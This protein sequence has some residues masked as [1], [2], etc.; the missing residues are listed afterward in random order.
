ML[1]SRGLK[2]RTKDTLDNPDQGQTQTPA[3]RSLHN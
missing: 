1:H 2:N 3:G